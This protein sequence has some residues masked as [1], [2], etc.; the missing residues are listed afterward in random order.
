MHKRRLLKL[1]DLLEADAK[2]PN[3]VKFDLGT[4]GWST[5]KP[6]VSCNTTACAMGVAALS[7]AF[8]YDG[9]TYFTRENGHS[10][11][12]IEVECQGRRGT[13]AA[14]RLFRITRRAA[15]WLFLE[16][17]YDDSTTGADGEFAVA[18]RIRDFV[19]GTVAPPKP[20]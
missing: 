3:G 16:D 11:I 6:D 18:K 12:L 19:A 14:A 9:L 20:L 15:D 7:G 10:G 17:W 8:E 1:A 13:A 2:N 4:W 5:T